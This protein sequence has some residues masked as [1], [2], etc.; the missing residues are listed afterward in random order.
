[1]LNVG[2]VPTLF[3]AEGENHVREA[4]RLM[5]AHQ[6]QL[7]VVGEARSAESL[8]ATVCRMPP[9]VILLDWELPGLHPQRLLAALRQCCPHSAVIATSVKPEH[10][11]SAR[12]HAVDGFVSKQLPPQEFI[13]AL[14]AVIRPT[15]TPAP[16]VPTDQ[17]PQGETS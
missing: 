12:A 16:T 8:L 13:D 2:A 10:R 17:T 4:L 7:A 6:P 14:L 9:D 15:R 11:Q 5:L 1:M 3:L